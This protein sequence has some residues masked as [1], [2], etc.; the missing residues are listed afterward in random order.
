MYLWLHI[1]FQLDSRLTHLRCPNILDTPSIY[2][3]TTVN[4]ILLPFPL[5]YAHVKYVSL[6]NSVKLNTIQTHSVVKHD[7]PKRL[8]TATVRFAI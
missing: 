7:A 1:I 3:C 2:I 6:C 5:K 4:D 8:F